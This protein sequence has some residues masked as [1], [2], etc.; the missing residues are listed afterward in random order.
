[1]LKGWQVSLDKTFTSREE[2]EAAFQA[3]LQT[4]D[5]ATPQIAA[6]TPAHQHSREMAAIIGPFAPQDLKALTEEK[7]WINRLNI[8]AAD[9]DIVAGGNWLLKFEIRQGVLAQIVSERRLSE[10]LAR[11]VPLQNDPYYQVIEEL[12]SAESLT[13]RGRDVEQLR[14]L[15][16]VLIWF[17]D[18]APTQI[19]IDEVE[20][21][22]ASRQLVEPFYK[23]TESFCGRDA[24]LELLRD[25]VEVYQASNLYE[26]MERSIKGAFGIRQRKPQVIW[27]TGGIGK[28]ALISR[29]ILEHAE[30]GA[31]V[32]VKVEGPRMIPYAYLDFDRV[33]LDPL[34][35][36]SLLTEVSLQLLKQYPNKD[37]EQQAIDWQQI[38]RR[39]QRRYARTSPDGPRGRGVT[40]DSRLAELIKNKLN[41]W[42]QFDL[43]ADSTLPPLLLVLDTFEEV[44]LGGEAR[45]RQ[46]AAFIEQMQEIYPRVR[47]VICGRAKVRYLSAHQQELIGLDTDSANA[48][49]RDKGID[50]I[51][52]REVIVSRIGTSPLSLILAAEAVRQIATE[53]RGTALEDIRT[54]NILLQRIDAAEIQGQLYDRI[55]KHIRDLGVRKLA[56]PGL[57]LRRI[58]P[59]IIRHVLAE[60]CGLNPD[61][62]EI[63]FNSIGDNVTLVNHNPDGSL[64]HRPDVRR[65]MIR[66]MLSGTRYSNTIEKIH[67]A[68]V[69][70]Y[71]TQAKHTAVTRGEHIYHLL[72]LDDVSSK[73]DSLAAEADRRS[74]EF[75]WEDPMPPRAHAWLTRY[76][77]FESNDV[78]W[79]NA[80]LG[81][82][83]QHVYGKAR[84]LLV[85]GEAEQALKRIRERKDRTPG[86]V[87]YLLETQALDQLGRIKPALK[88][89]DAGINSALSSASTATALRLAMLGARLAL[90]LND[91]IRFKQYLNQG[92]ELTRPDEDVSAKLELSKLRLDG[93]RQLKSENTEEEDEATML[94]VNSFLQAP[95]EVLWQ[96]GDL[97]GDILSDIGSEYPVLLEHAINVLKPVG[98]GDIGTDGYINILSRANENEAFKQRKPALLRELGVSDP[99]TSWEQVAQQSLDYGTFDKAL[100]AVVRH[101]A[102]GSN[103]LRSVADMISPHMSGFKK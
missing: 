96:E 56:H 73:L 13:L 16:Q 60:P 54:R 31:N 4:V 77:G 61:D 74:L 51:E 19:S 30:I 75:A 103:D 83:E 76:L 25:Y 5:T 3:A 8:I 99:E 100:T 36:E 46:V 79:K 44:Q 66:N 84:E 24:E 53:N 59:D 22:L 69:N 47:V 18:A 89:V 81:D 42:L 62:A 78:D 85:T 68:A 71:A 55:L 10:V 80:E 33:E 70:Y 88:V 38:I 11:S 90:K 7:E 86:S 40:P 21:A 39:S 50:E 12:A 65:V 67:R 6:I 63:L 94:L 97:T 49:L 92:A 82:W 20:Q 15:R 64:Q 23:L 28:S 72:M 48:L 43:F 2:F 9:C 57:V 101:G 45:E 27:G 95:E 34:R 91:H 102:L 29:F 26:G 1:M 98:P 17:G 87:L 93:F 32:D 35:P 37:L 14:R 41:D 52:M 58:T